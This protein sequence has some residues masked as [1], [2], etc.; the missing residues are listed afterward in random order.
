MRWRRSDLKQVIEAASTPK[1]SRRPSSNTDGLAPIVPSVANFLL[2]RV[3]VG[4]RVFEALQRRGACLKHPVFSKYR[5]ETEILRYM[6]KLADRDPAGSRR[7]VDEAE[8][9]ARQALAE[10]RSAVTGIRASD[11]AAE[12]ASARLLLEYQ[13][14]HLHYA[15]P[16]PMPV[17]PSE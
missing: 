10:V 6:R 4:G 16:P 17:A 1:V 2:V 13:H 7:E 3:G 11:L 14:V 12:L 9:I 8:T 15:P 5:S